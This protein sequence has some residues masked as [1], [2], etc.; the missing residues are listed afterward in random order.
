MTTANQPLDEPIR[1]PIERP[2]SVRAHLPDAT[3]DAWHLPYY[4]VGPENAQL[5]VLYADNS[6]LSLENFS[7][8]LLYGERG[9]GKTTLAVTLA[10]RW[11]RMTKLRPL[12]FASA[13]EFLRDYVSA[14]EIDDIDSF[15]QRF[16]LCKLL[17]LDG[18]DAL[19]GHEAAQ[20]E[21]LHTLDVLAEQRCPVLITASQLP[22]THGPRCMSSCLVS[23][24]LSGL[25][26]QINRPS[27]TTM[28]SILDELITRKRARKKLE[29]ITDILHPLLDR[30]SVR[31]L[32]AI[33]DA[34]IDSIG[35]S[36]SLTP[37]LV[38]Q[39]VAIHQ[40]RPPLSIADI[41]K[42]VADK[43][44]TRLSTLRAASRESRIV[45]AR[46]IAMLLCRQ[47]TP[48]TLA[49]IGRYFGGRDHSTVLHNCQKTAAWIDSDPEFAA[50]VAD[51]R[52]DL[53]WKTG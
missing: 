6:I 49:D 27:P 37:E 28:R 35:S 10:V 21:L 43:T 14:I 7:P 1:L 33:V 13:A 32:Y 34:I 50:V 12:C 31:E 3:D 15:R 51:I 4:F 41:A 20:I 45:R 2:A 38:R 36:R 42:A 11:S 53:M 18:L 40:S 25:S 19:I 23:R 17:V 26:I 16:R 9:C 30:L 47:M 48:A 52:N 24:L 46:G 29:G 5:S 44:N 22:S 8:C 39:Q